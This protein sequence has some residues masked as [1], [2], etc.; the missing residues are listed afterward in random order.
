MDEG[1]GR[2]AS[3]RAVRAVL[4]RLCDVVQQG[5]DRAAWIESNTRRAPELTPEQR[6]LAESL[7]ARHA[8]AGRRD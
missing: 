2:K 7:H 1:R 8:R 5:F 3:P 4:N 6:S